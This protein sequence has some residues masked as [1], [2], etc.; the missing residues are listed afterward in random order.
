MTA[1]ATLW[2]A[3]RL[4]G[5]HGGH[6]G[7]VEFVAPLKNIEKTISCCVFENLIRGGHLWGAVAPLE[8][9][10]NTGGARGPRPLLGRV[11]PPL[12]EAVSLC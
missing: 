11:A 7:A 8:T 2:G 5:G 9:R 3:I 12:R 6:G 4:K 1:S 10:I